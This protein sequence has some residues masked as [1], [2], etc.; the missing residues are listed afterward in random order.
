MAALQT[1]QLLGLLGAVSY[2]LARL[3]RASRSAAWHRYAVVA[4]PRSGLPTMPRG[5]AVREL[6]AAEL[7]GQEIDASPAV[8]AERFAAGLTCLGAFD[9][10][11][12]LTGLVWLGTGTYDEDEVAVR[13]LLPADCCWDT[14]L[15][16]A[17]EHR[18]GRTFAALWA[19]VKA[20]MARA[21]ADLLA[22]PDQR[23]QPDCAHARICGCRRGCWRT[24]PLCGSATG[25]GAPPRGRGWCSCAAR[26]DQPARC[27]TCADLIWWAAR[28][29]RRG[30]SA[31]H[32]VRGGNRPSRTGVRSSSP[33]LK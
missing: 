14:G 17:P 8:Q 27:S 16:I 29:F 6:S 15:W 24:A 2:G 12:Q 3:A 10:R 4:Q 21:R 26:T 19:G 32:N 18:M 28:R 5:F 11:G 22:Q 13:F 1:I 9:P 30:A 25:N 20:W 31:P 33:R 7:A 23:L